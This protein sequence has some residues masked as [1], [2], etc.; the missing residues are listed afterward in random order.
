MIY[1][2]KDFLVKSVSVY[3]SFHLIFLLRGDFTNAFAY[4]VGTVI[5]F[6]VIP[7]LLNKLF[8]IRFY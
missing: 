7:K 3:F 4:F 8:N 2:S 1:F 5:G 6:Y